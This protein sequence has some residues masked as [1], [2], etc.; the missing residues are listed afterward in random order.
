MILYLIIYVTGGT[1]AKK[2]GRTGSN[3]AV[4]ARTRV[5]DGRTSGFSPQTSLRE[6]ILRSK[7]VPATCEKGFCV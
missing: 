7:S 5:R 2:V 6:G 3:L 1:A 4:F